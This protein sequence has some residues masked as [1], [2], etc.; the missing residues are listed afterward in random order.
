MIQLTVSN[1]KR[2]KE[3]EIYIKLFYTNDSCSPIATSKWIKESKSKKI[4]HNM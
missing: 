4:L 3:S 1:L 2:I